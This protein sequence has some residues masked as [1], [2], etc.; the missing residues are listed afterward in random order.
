MNS[1][2][3]FSKAQGNDIWGSDRSFDKNGTGALQKELS[4]QGFRL[5]P[6]DGKGLPDVLD[7]VIYSAAVEPDNPDL[8]AAQSRHIQILSRAQW[9][10]E[11]FNQKKGIAVS[12][13]SGKS[14]VTGMI[15]QILETAGMDFSFI[16]G[17]RIKK[18]GK[19]GKSSNW[20]S[21][22]GP[23]MVIEAD[24]SDGT[25]VLYKPSYAIV[26]NISKDH[27]EIDELYPMFERLLQSTKQAVILNKNCPFSKKLTELHRNIRFFSKDEAKGIQQKKHET[28]FET[29]IGKIHLKVP[30]LHNIDNALASIEMALTLDVSPKNI[31]DGLKTFCG[32][33]RRLDLIGS[34]KEIS[35]Y[36]DFS[37]NPV[38]IEAAIQTLKNIHHSIQVVYQPHGFGP[39]KQQWNELLSV[40]KETLGAQDELYL[41]PVYDAGGTAD[42]S[43]TSED[44]SEALRKKECP[45]SFFSTRTALIQH[46]KNTLCGR[47]A[48]IVM[49]A[50]DPSLTALAHDILN[51]LKEKLD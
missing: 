36:D 22:K 7:T 9:L 16:S 34:S 18:F 39:L 47:N 28:C 31:Q 50:R 13:T 37:H 10:A 4:E 27:K 48:V 25:L 20:K 6:Q 15:A 45:V 42:R 51:A 3:L 30:G 17:G 33:E 49:G 38:K 43:I 44:F 41:L 14:T 1:L 24:E 19:N 8:M 2:A 12:G 29:K 23:L 5:V 11:I 26:T 32:I 46:L 35:V 40:F 21:G